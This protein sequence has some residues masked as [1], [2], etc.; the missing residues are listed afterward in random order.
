M[1]IRT[2]FAVICCAFCAALAFPTSINAQG[3]VN[4]PA[5]ASA[6]PDSL[7]YKDYYGSYKMDENP[8]VQKVKAYFKNGALYG[9]AEGYP[10]G[11]LTQTQ[12]DDFTTQDGAAAVSFIRTAGAVTGIKVT[13][14]GQDMMGKKEAEV[15]AAVADFQQYTGD[16]KMAEG[17]PT[18]SMKVYVKDGQLYGQADGYPETKLTLVK[19]DEFSESNFGATILFTRKDNTVKGIKISVQGTELEGVK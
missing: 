5:A 15:A 4:K 19:G 13:A 9:Q 14:Q 6:V 1:K 16:Y 18:P 8:Y 2:F 17:S 11:P 3:A 12:G 7:K 10:E